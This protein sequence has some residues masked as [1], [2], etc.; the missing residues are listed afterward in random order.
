M[1]FELPVFPGAYIPLCGFSDIL[2]SAQRRSHNTFTYYYMNDLTLLEE[3]LHKLGPL[4][5]ALS[6]T[7]GAVE[8]RRGKKG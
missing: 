1:I 2:C 7:C 5:T 6:V 8:A 4:V 3:G